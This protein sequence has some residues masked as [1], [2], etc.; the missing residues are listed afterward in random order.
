[1]KRGLY[2]TRNNTRINY[3]LC[4]DLSNLYRSVVASTINYRNYVAPSVL[5]AWL[6]WNGVVSLQR[7]GRYLNAACQGY[8]LISAY[9][10]TQRGLYT[11]AHV[12]MELFIQHE[13]HHAD[14]LTAQLRSERWWVYRTLTHL[15]HKRNNNLNVFLKKNIICHHVV[16]IS[17]WNFWITKSANTP[18]DWLG[19]LTGFNSILIWGT[20]RVEMQHR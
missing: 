7:C 9:M 20:K 11:H 14:I 4:V 12:W 16:K 1:M 2:K 10:H 17:V 8:T 5:Y 6:R 18:R 13:N 19:V 3:K 15:S